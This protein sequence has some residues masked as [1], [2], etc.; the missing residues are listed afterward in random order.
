MSKAAF[1][2]KVFA[3]YLAGLGVILLFVPN[4]LLGLFGFAATAE[5]WI[6]VLGV[7]IINLGVYYWF[8]AVSESVPFFRASVATRVFV[9]VA[10][11]GLAAAGLALP[12]LILFGAVDTLGGLWTHLALRADTQRA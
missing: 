6:R 5:V 8:A 11:A 9:L 12:T 7:V 1:S 10:F 2:V 3:V 4:L